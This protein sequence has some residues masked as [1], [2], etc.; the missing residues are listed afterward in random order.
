MNTRRENVKS[1]NDEIYAAN[2]KAAESAKAGVAPFTVDE[3]GIHFDQDLSYDVLG[4]LYG[5]ICDRLN[6][7]KRSRRTP[8]NV[9]SKASL[10]TKQEIHDRV[11]CE[12]MVEAM[13]A[14]ALNK[15]W[16]LDFY[17]EDE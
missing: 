12:R 7:L 2:D 10:A 15:N 13:E 6:T 17:G 11:I 1:H 8:G 4:I 3:K 14:Y 16:D 9:S 5:E